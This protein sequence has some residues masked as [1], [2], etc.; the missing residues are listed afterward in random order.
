M[1]VS[2]FDVIAGFA[3]DNNEDKTQKIKERGEELREQRLLY[4]QI[5][6][7]RYATDEKL[8]AKHQEKYLERNKA[9]E[10]LGG[11][12][13]K[14]EIAAKLALLDGRNID[15]ADEKQRAF[16]LQS[17]YGDIQEQNKKDSNGKDMLDA[18]GNSLKQLVY[19]GNH[20][21]IAPAWGKKYYNPQTFFDAKDNI[22]AGTK[23]KWTTAI[24]GEGF[25]TGDQVLA[26]LQNDLEQG[27]ERNVKTWD[28][29]FE[30]NN[31]VFDAKEGSLQ[32]PTPLDLSALYEN[33][34]DKQRTL[35][36]EFIK[37][38]TFKLDDSA[39]I[40]NIAGF[41]SSITGDE[42]AR[43]LETS[44]Q[45]ETVLTEEAM[46]MGK[47]YKEAYETAIHEIGK[48]FLT[49]NLGDKNQI[50]PT[51]ADA[52]ALVDDWFKTNYMILEND[53]FASK[54]NVAA[55]YVPPSIKVNSFVPSNIKNALSDRLNDVL[56]FT[57]EQL[58]QTVADFQKAGIR[59]APVSQT[60]DFAQWKQLL[61]AES[62]EFL[63]NQTLTDG[64][65]LIDDEKNK[66]NGY[67]SKEI[68]DGAGVRQTVTG[69][70]IPNPRSKNEY[71]ENMFVP[72]QEFAQRFTQQD[73]TEEEIKEYFVKEATEQAY[74]RFRE[75]MPIVSSTD[76]N[77]VSSS[78]SIINNNEEVVSLNLTNYTSFAPPKKYKNRKSIA[79]D[80]KP[81]QEFLDWSS[82]NLNNWE[83]FLNNVDVGNRPK[84]SDYSSP[85]GNER[86]STEFSKALGEYNKKINDIKRYKKQLEELKLYSTMEPYKD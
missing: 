34:T 46:V 51:A 43:F 11:S 4:Q 5:A 49:G 10:S 18:D 29:Y 86:M 12:A 32:D 7:N 31:N 83:N 70:V 40:K 15:G 57:D 33:A 56:Q 39:R 78:S 6:M 66:D 47:M 82:E 71:T 26:T 1:G 79:G 37:G 74:Y 13:T 45:G 42:N 3:K 76:D 41:L 85:T 30:K 72:W 58:K 67:Y 38:N 80:Y 20:E 62:R 23:G 8:F 84:A 77:E 60:S 64:A 22:E 16:I 24:R 69:L 81:T 35:Y 21:P 27:A 9:L 25:D 61:D 55:L 52:S 28:E 53:T 75:V 19:T 59:I 2:A 68:V 48:R 54:G 36:Q 44:Q 50:L 73:F 65:S 63:G 17:Y 14:D